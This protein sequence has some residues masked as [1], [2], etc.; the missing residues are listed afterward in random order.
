MSVPKSLYC[1][2]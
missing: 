2:R 1:P